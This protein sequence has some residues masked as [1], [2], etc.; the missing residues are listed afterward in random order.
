MAE[1]FK[2][3]FIDE[4]SELLSDLELSL[5]NLEKRPD[6]AN[7]IARIFRSLHTIKGSS[8][9][10][11]YPNVSEFTHNI[12][13]VFHHIRIGDIQIT[14]DIID[15]TLLARDQISNML[16]SDETDYEQKSIVEKELITAIRKYLPESKS[17]NINKIN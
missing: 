9:M 4:A 5:I 12:E 2:Q 14:K 1:D 16:I 15:L 3:A 17:K 13:S 10:F 6:D 11:G 7:I 8:V